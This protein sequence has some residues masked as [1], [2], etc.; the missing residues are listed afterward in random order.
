MVSVSAAKKISGKSL[1]KK[2]QSIT[3]AELQ[4]TKPEEVW[5]LN[6]SDSGGRVLIRVGTKDNESTLVI[7]QTWIPQLLTNDTTLEAMLVSDV[8]RRAVS[9][10]P[11]NGKL[12][13]IK[14]ISAEDAQKILSRDDS[15]LEIKEIRIR[16]EE[17]AEARKIDQNETIQKTK[18]DEVDRIKKKKEKKVAVP[19]GIVMQ[20]LN[21]LHEGKFESRDMTQFLRQKKAS[22]T[23]DDLAYIV[24]ESSDAV[25]KQ[26]A[27]KFLEKRGIAKA[28]SVYCLPK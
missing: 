14:L 8:F 17:L 28:A 18:K 26:T 23:D 13:A 10:D 15:I 12:P 7:H 22:L 4:K 11:I 25:V 21:R 5:A 6:V 9:G 1:S 3:L 27:A 16:N 2:A 24:L 20:A 19:S